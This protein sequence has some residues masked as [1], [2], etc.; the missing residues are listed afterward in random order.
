MERKRWDGGTGALRR[1]KL[2]ESDH[3]RLAGG[4]FAT[5]SELPNCAVQCITHLVELLRHLRL[6]HAIPSLTVGKLTYF[7]LYGDRAQ[8]NKSG[9]QT[10]LFPIVDV[11]QKSLENAFRAHLIGKWVPAGLSCKNFP[12]SHAI[13]VSVLL[14][15]R[16]G[17][18][19]A[20]VVLLS[21]VWR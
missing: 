21:V 7:H 14:A 15:A 6:S 20:L 4:R 13:L 11:I 2:R 3:R 1:N 17:K 18:V 8:S 19:K 12:D 5:Y 10:S 9:G 16:K